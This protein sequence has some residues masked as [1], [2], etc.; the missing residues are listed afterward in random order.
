MLAPLGH[1]PPFSHIHPPPPHGGRRG[2]SSNG[3]SSSTTGT[4]SVGSL[5]SGS[6]V[7]KAK[8]G[9]RGGARLDTSVVTVEYLEQ[10]GLLAL[11]EHDAAV[12]LGVGVNT[13]KRHCRWLVDGCCV[14]MTQMIAV[15]VC[16]CSDVCMFAYISLKNTHRRLG[17]MRWPGRKLRA[18]GGRKGSAPLYKTAPIA[19]ATKPQSLTPNGCAVRLDMAPAGATAATPTAERA[20]TSSDVEGTDEAVDDAMDEDDGGDAG[21]HNRDAV[22]G[23]H[24][25][26]KR[27]MDDVHAAAWPLL[28][29]AQ[30]LGRDVGKPPLTS[31]GGALGVGGN[32]HPPA[33]AGMTGAVAVVHGQAGVVDEHMGGAEGDASKPLVLSAGNVFCSV[34]APTTTTTTRA[35]PL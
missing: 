23:Q 14:W 17:L 7:E 8:A 26:S 18:K 31:V 21:R 2:T 34:G 35:S 16:V 13:L 9:R 30:E 25:Q 3:H 24:P 5:G 19:A 22:G 4:Y 32:V 6:G 10:Q 15:F 11:P 12:Q 28:Q 20:T 1:A 27:P 29:L 33:A